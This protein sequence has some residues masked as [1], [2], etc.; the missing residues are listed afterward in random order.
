MKIGKY[1]INVGCA[2]ALV[3]AGLV[4]LSLGF[5]ITFLT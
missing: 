1:K 2:L 5:L 3:Y 4:A